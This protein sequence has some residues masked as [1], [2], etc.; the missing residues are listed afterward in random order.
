MQTLAFMSEEKMDKSVVGGDGND[1][2]EH[3]K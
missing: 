2:A 1:L 3:P